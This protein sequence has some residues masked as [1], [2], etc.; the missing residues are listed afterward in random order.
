MACSTSNIIATSWP[1]TFSIYSGPF[2]S[3]LMALHPDLFQ[4]AVPWTLLLAIWMVHLMPRPSLW[5]VP[6][7]AWLGGNDTG[8]DTGPVGE[9][10]KWMILPGQLC[11]LTL[12]DRKLSCNR[13]FFYIWRPPGSSIHFSSSSHPC[14][15]TFGS[16]VYFVD[17]FH[18]EKQSHKGS[19]SS[20]CK[21][22]YYVTRDPSL[23]RVLTLSSWSR[24]DSCMKIINHAIVL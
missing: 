15:S 19:V 5:L 14:L 13:S 1:Q 23:S 7:V 16:T 12:C 21:A 10:D 9:M 17:K 8:N 11:V 6:C 20:V 2:R 4:A 3:D 18:F 24:C 22:S